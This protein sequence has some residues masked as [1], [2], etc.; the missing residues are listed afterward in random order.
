MEL[1]DFEDM[2]EAIDKITQLA[3][4]KSL[5]EIEIKKL[6][7]SVFTTAMTDQA[8]FQGGKPPSATFIENAY[9]FTGLNGEIV[10]LRIRLATV[11]SALENDKLN[12]DL[13]KDA[14]EIWRSEQAT[15]RLSLN[16]S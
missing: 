1:P 6:E 2:A 16:L 4:E 5:L 13:M 15:Q 12:F 7:C 8:Y 11:C 3:L 9:K 10:P 14:I